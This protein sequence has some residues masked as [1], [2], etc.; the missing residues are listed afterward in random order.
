MEATTRI[1]KAVAYLEGLEFTLSDRLAKVR[2]STTLLKGSLKE[3]E[4]LQIKCRAYEE[5]LNK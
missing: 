5:I 1:K 3:I 2:N 4:K